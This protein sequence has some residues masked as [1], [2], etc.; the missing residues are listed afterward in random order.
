M[1]HETGSGSPRFAKLSNV[2]PYSPIS[3]PF[4]GSLKGTL[5]PYIPTDPRIPEF[6]NPTA[7]KLFTSLSA[8]RRQGYSIAREWERLVTDGHSFCH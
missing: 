8:R 6:L 7:L 3:T 5:N 2:H 4:E 1:I